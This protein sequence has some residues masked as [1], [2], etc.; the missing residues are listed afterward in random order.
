MNEGLMG[1]SVLVTGAAGGIGRAL[2]RQLVERGAAP[3]LHYRSSESAASELASE[4]DLD[5]R[6]VVQ[7]DLRHEDEVVAMFDRVDRG[8]PTGLRSLVVNAGVWPERDVAIR[9]MD[10][11]QWK[12]TLACNLDSAFLCCREFLRRLPDTV[13]DPSIVLIGSTS[14]RFG[15]EGH[16]DYSS[17][18]AAMRGLMLTL[19]N[20]IVRRHP[21]GRI[22]LVSPGWVATPMAEPALADQRIVDRVTSTMAL[23]KVASPDDVARAVLFFLSSVDAGHVSGQELVVAGGMEGRLLHPAKPSDPAPDSA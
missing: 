2:M 16:G 12:N 10:F 23:R 9:D 19:K 15:E 11:Q 22:N 20:E 5:R 21:R 14:G 13:E 1:R 18:K 6:R 7:A 4:L 17:S 3:W 8:E